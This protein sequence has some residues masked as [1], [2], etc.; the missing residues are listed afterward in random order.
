[1]KFNSDISGIEADNSEAK[2]FKNLFQ[3]LDR[4]SPVVDKKQ[5]KKPITSNTSENDEK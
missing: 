2:T 1:M 4:I 5:S 3:G